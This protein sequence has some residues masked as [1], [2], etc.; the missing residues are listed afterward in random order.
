M[1]A[2][3]LMFALQQVNPSPF[4]ILDEVDAALDDANVDRFGE[5]LER[6]GR[7]R[8]FLVV[9]HNHATM[10]RA[11]ALYGVHLDESGTSHLVSVRLDG[12]GENAPASSAQ[13]TA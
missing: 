3:A 7:E 8:Q 13:A 1:T 12:V 10:A 5:A 6:L 4:V 9:T 2:L 11:S